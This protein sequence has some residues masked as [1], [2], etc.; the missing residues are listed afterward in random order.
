LSI[1]STFLDI[2]FNLLYNQYA[3]LYDWVAAIVSVGRWNRWVDAVIPDLDG[4]RIL[5]L[6]HGPGHLQL[7]LARSGYYI[8]GLD[9]SLQMGRLAYY[10]IAKSG[11]SPKLVRGIS[12]QL[13]F[14]ADK[15]DQVVSTFPSKYIFDATT[16]SGIYRVLLPG[17]KLVVL[18]VAW[19]DRERFFDRLA[20]WLF[21]FTR[22]AP[23]WKATLAEP[24]IA[25]GFQ[26]KIDQRRLASSEV[27]IIIATKPS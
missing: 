14:P 10:R 26:I 7:T 25:A 6:G 15:F 16:L 8:I 19:I 2:F 4:P 13:P 18:P 3:R 17:G 27:L 11:F 22:Q 1:L 9:S 21:N 24:F 5:E 23:K 12:Q 20:A